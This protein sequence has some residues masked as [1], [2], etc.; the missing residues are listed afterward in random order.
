MEKCDACRSLGADVAV[1]YRSEDF[2]AA[3]KA[4]TDGKGAGIVLDIV[5]VV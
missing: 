4:A 3:T 1:N 5:L 2:V